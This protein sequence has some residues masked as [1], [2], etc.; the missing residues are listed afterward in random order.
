LVSSILLLPLALSAQQEPLA[1][2]EQQSPQPSQTSDTPAPQD[3]TGSD[4]LKLPVVLNLATGEILHSPI[5]PLHWGRLSMISTNFYYAYDSNV[6][7][8]P[9][10]PSSD[11]LFGVRSLIVYSIGNKR[12]SFTFQYQPFALASR[13]YYEASGAGQSLNFDT[14]HYLSHRWLL[15]ISDSYRYMPGQ[16]QFDGASFVQDFS[17][18]ALT[19]QPLLTAGQEYQENSLNASLSRAISPRDQL[20]FNS[21][22]GWYDVSSLADSNSASQNAIYPAHSNETLGTG[23]TWTHQWTPAR[24]FGL[25]YHFSRSVFNAAYP[26]SEYYSVF[27]NYE[28]QIRPT[29][30]VWISLG[31]ALQMTAPAAG[32]A[33]QRTQSV[34]TYEGSFTLMKTFQR[35]GISLS[36]S[37]GEGFNG[38]ISNQLTNQAFIAYRRDLGRR[39]N[40]NTGIGYVE[41]A[42]LTGQKVEGQSV[43]T[44]LGWALSRSWSTVVSYSFTNITGGVSPLSGRQFVSIG[45]QWSL[46]PRK[47]G[48]PGG[49]KPAH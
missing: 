33:D 17:S 36:L 6:L 9:N 30:S 35:S 15:G 44:S 38:L 23:L 20:T 25:S 29:V 37:R 41:Q 12:S 21:S 16:A 8:S 19:E 32:S 10:N 26:A 42:D 4:F 7:F 48:A 49:A 27:A 3:G 5:S 1:E 46:L 18:G 40:L 28:Q 22:L 2:Q 34:L 45:V 13:H 31:P 11:R 14:Y 47:E 43:W 24:E 39:W